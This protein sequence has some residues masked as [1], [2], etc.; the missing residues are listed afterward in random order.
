MS[1]TK[2]TL[3]TALIGFRKS[4]EAV[5]KTE[6]NPFFKSKYADLPNILEAIKAPLG[7][8]GL[9]LYHQTLSNEGSFVVITT[10]IESVSG[11]S[12]TSMFPV[13]GSKPQE[14]GSSITYARRYNIQ[15]LLD[16]PTDDDD[17]NEANKSEPVKTEE[18]N[19]TQKQL[20]LIK[21]LAQKAGH[22]EAAINAVIT[23]IKTQ[24][25]ASA[26]I[27]TLIN[28]RP[29]PKPAPATPTPADVEA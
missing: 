10:L 11:E 4:I 8:N 17:G 5:K 15:A 1:E 9:A 18:P 28:A 7:D 25:Q 13:F 27:E 20:T 29:K 12:I 22:N 19:A 21:E 16:I 14:I 23:S 2:K 26:K 24:S 6:D 3:V